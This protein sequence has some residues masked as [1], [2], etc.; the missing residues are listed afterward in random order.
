[1][2]EGQVRVCGYLINCC[3]SGGTYYV[4]VTP[5]WGICTQGSQLLPTRATTEL[6]VWV[7]HTHLRE[8]AKDLLRKNG[9]GVSRAEWGEKVL[10]CVLGSNEKLLH[11]GCTRTPACSP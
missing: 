6:R 8:R 10:E 3:L 2:G 11:N 7:L 4:H 1:M 9:L 5:T